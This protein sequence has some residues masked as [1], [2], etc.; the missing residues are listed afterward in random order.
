MLPNSKTLK[1]TEKEETYIIEIPFWHFFGISM[2]ILEGE[3]FL[4]LILFE[5]LGSGKRLFYKRAKIQFPI[6]SR[7]KPVELSGMVIIIIKTG[8]N[9][10][11]LVLLMNE[12]DIDV[13]KHFI[14]AKW[15][16]IEKEAEIKKEVRLLQK[17][18]WPKC[19]FGY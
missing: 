10:L 11:W 16:T 4:C 1:K 14:S 19:S 6:H 13:N 2:S 17:L 18:S 5:G 7:R 15:T 3:I 8:K 9:G 12:V